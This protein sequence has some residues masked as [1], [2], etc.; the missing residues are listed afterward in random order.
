MPHLLTSNE[1]PGTP[2]PPS[3]PASGP[4]LLQFQPPGEDEP[5]AL[6]TA[7]HIPRTEQDLEPLRR[8]V[9]SIIEAILA[10]TG[11]E[12]AEVREKLRRHVA[13]NPGRPEKALLKHLLCLSVREDE[14]LSGSEPSAV[15]AGLPDDFPP[16]LLGEV[17]H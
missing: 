15:N 7:R 6:R 5:R 8:Q 14:A 9:S 11:P 12:E 1:L 2:T 17:R 4:R 3:T 13:K 10:E 16:R